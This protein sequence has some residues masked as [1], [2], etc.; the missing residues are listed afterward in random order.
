LDLRERKTLEDD[1]NFI[2]RRICFKK[3]LWSQRNSRC[4]VLPAPNNRGI[5]TIRDMTRAAVAMEQLSKHV[6]AEKNSRNSRI[7]VFCVRSVP[8][9][10]KKD[11][12]DV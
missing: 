9:G 2:L 5:V 6:S 3:E 7:A 10:Y 4:Y 12:E 11:K 1:E 8:R